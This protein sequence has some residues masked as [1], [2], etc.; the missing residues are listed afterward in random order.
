ML[1]QIVAEHNGQALVTEHFANGEER[2]FS[3]D[4][5]RAEVRR[6]EAKAY[7]RYAVEARVYLTINEKA[8][9]KRCPEF[10]WVKPDNTMY[11]TIEVDGN[12]IFDSREHIPCGT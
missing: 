12:P 2:L 1:S 6:H 10:V 3:V 11:V 5:A 7:I 4:G 8:K 9:R